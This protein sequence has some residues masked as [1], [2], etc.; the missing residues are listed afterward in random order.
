MSVPVTQ[1]HN[2]HTRTRTHRQWTFHQWYALF[3]NLYF[4]CWF[5]RQCEVDGLPC[6]I[7]FSDTHLEQPK[8]ARSWEQ[9]GKVILWE[10][11][12]VDFS[13]CTDRY[14][15]YIPVLCRVRRQ[16][17]CVS[18]DTDSNLCHKY[19]LSSQTEQ[20][21]ASTYTSDWQ[22]KSWCTRCTP[23]HLWVCHHKQASLRGPKHLL[24]PL[25]IQSN[26][27]IDAFWIWSLGKKQKGKTE[28]SGQISTLLLDSPA[29]DYDTI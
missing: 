18:F 19:N 21:A 25:L 4:L 13:V 2:T 6:S 12:C 24:R 29:N 9:Q 27:S 22:P 8:F 17:A 20:E 15:V 26:K 3:K 28:G 1:N 14:P 23:K 11:T 5:R 16:P 10:Q 7:C